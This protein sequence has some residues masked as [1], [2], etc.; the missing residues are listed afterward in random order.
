MNIG[1]SLRQEVWNFLKLMSNVFEITLLLQTIYYRY[2][3]QKIFDRFDTKFRAYFKFPKI[4]F[5]F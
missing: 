5:N 3:L 2:F 1:M 4:D